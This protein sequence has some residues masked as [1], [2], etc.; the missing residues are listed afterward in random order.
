L[1]SERQRNESDAGAPASESPPRDRQITVHHA[2][3]VED[4]DPNVSRHWM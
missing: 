1:T 4:V 3:H 2:D